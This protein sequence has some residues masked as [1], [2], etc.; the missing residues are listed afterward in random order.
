MIAELT[1]HLWQSTIFVLVV[2]MAAVLLRRNRAQ[3]RYAL[4]LAASAKFLVPFSLLVSLGTL[5]PWRT[6]R[7]AIVPAAPA[8]FTV[9]V[10]QI[11]EPFPVASPAPPVPTTRVTWTPVVVAI[12]CLGFVA[13]VT[14][15]FR[16]W[17]RIRRAIQCS[18]PAT[19][20]VGESI[21]VR[22]SS[23]ML[24]PGVVGLWRPILL[25]PDGITESLTRQQLETVIVH[26][27]CH[28]RRR[29]NLT[30]VVHMCVEAVCWFHPLVWWIGAR[31]LVERER[32]CDEA[33]LT[34]G[35]Q[36]RDYADAILSVC[37]L[38][39]ESPLAC[40]SGVTGSDLKRRI[41]DIMFERTGM[42]LTRAR[43]AAL[44]LSGIAALAAPLAIGSVTAA[45]RAQDLPSGPAFDVAT[46]KPCDPQAPVP[47]GRG[48]GGSGVS[49]DRLDLECR[50]LVQL[51]NTAYIVNGEGLLNDDPGSV[52]R[53]PDGSGRFVPSAERVR[54]GP[55]WANNDKFTIEAK[56]AGATDPKVLQGPMLRALLEQRFHL[57]IHR[58][59]D[60]NVDMLALT[61]GKDGPK[62][63]AW[64][65][66]TDCTPVDPATRP[67]TPMKD[68]IAAATQG[69][70]PSCQA[71]EI[72][73]HNGSNATFA[74]NAMD[75][76]HVAYWLSTDVGRHVLNQ[77]GLTGKYSLYLEFSPPDSLADATGPSV[78][79]A[80]QEQWGLKLEPAKG[81]RGYLVID[82]AERPS[83]GSVSQSS[84][85]S[86]TFDVASVRPCAQA[87]AAPGGRSGGGNGS[88]SPGRVDLNCFL[89][90]N[91]I[92][93]AYVNPR[94]GG[95]ADDPLN[96][97][98][99]LLT[100]LDPDS[101]QPIRGGPAWVYS[102]KYT[103]EAKADGLDPSANGADRQIAM[104][105]MLRS[106][107]QDRFKL[108]MHREI[109]EPSM[110]AL[111][112]AKG[113]LKVKPITE[114]DCTND[115]SKGTVLVSDALKRGVKPT[116]GTI[117]GGADGPN[118]RY[119][120]GGQDFGP[121]AEVLSSDLGIMVVD[122]TGITDKFNITWEYGPDDSTPGIHRWR[123]AFGLAEP[124]AP[125]TAPD[126]FTALREQIGL[127]L[128]KIKGTRA[129]LQI[130]HIERPSVDQ[131]P[132][133]SGPPARAQGP[134]TP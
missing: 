53:S 43:K 44:A 91:L 4:W 29:D 30:A 109:E 96:R 23:T 69:A 103:I 27:L 79:T 66:D 15:R 99:R 82:G 64:P 73:G 133:V 9:A 5:I 49:P 46:I 123:E 76:D 14:V 19:L 58:A 50:T 45:V 75:M 114:G 18:V 119:D 70:K 52:Q 10:D 35:L 8:A 131:Q 125:P 105:P 104:G 36:P 102:D 16:A 129:Y 87:S 61:V 120:E 59:E 2:A 98:P 63:K 38:C 71:D 67:A 88:F 21:E 26:E 94:A 130:D 89:V 115:L 55:D 134:R 121:L 107:L 17:H 97:Y 48:G 47:G 56:A 72:R 83:A 77:T 112:V 126:I 74:L 95:Q 54:G 37:K 51:V 84:T 42:N 80:V 128:Q 13:I 111:T 92:Q 106:L 113:G 34:H 40:V 90:R 31:L 132:G 78:F 57:K 22:T 117:R 62:I 68:L 93:T 100:L 39:V 85:R 28:A 124:T 20:D 6:S 122:R 86:Q 118:W 101:P 33:V 127:Q 41:N 108:Q 110:Y 7:S 81:P 1:N 25:L 3:V 11:A 32:A 65:T 12:W 60:Q 116:C 24:E